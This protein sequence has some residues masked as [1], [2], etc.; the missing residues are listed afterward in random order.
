MVALPLAPVF[1]DVDT[2]EPPTEVPESTVSGEMTA[3][4]TPTNESVS[5]G[6]PPE[7]GT[8]TESSG[9]GGPEIPIPTEDI[10]TSDSESTTSLQ[11]VVENTDTTSGGQNENTSTSSQH[12][13]PSTVVNADTTSTSENV[14]TD[15]AP[16]HTLQES[17]T[18]AYT[19]PT[20]PLVNTVVNDEN[21]FSF[22][23]SECTT[24][25]DGTY[26]C[27]K[28]KE[29]PEVEHTDRVFSAVDADGDLE[30]FL[31]KDGEITQIT[32]N[33]LDDDA[34]YYDESSNSLTWHRLIDG[35]YQIMTYDIESRT[36]RQV[37]FDR[38]NNMQPSRFGDVIVWQGW[39]GND[40][41]VFMEKGNEQKMITDNTTHDI[42]PRINGTHII[43]QAYEN[44]TWV[45]KVYDIRTAQ[46]ETIHGNDGGSVENPR[47]VLV[48]DTKTETGDV[49]VR[50][51]DLDSGETVDL[52]ARP[53]PIPKEIP[54]PDQTGQDRALV[55]PSTQVVKEK[56]DVTPD[57]GNGN[58][59]EN[60]RDNG[61]TSESDI[62]LPPFISTGSSTAS[63][64]S[65][66]NSVY[67][68]S[69][70]IS[71][72]QSSDVVVPMFEKGEDT[73]VD[74]IPTIIVTPY[75]EPIDIDM[76]GTSEN[77]QI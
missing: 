8:H 60:E 74:T 54:N 18:T 20:K 51:Y 3:S 53:K 47:F 43:W 32:H 11:I 62:I 33:Q 64:T 59:P 19:E 55:S 45:M 40:W 39:V 1:A 46:I 65:I 70:K 71:S 73:A 37:T 41:E 12:E 16:Q 4:D 28:H 27:V 57:G 63:S 2:T 23:K 66:E 22:A 49:S 61:A 31:E 29:E 35:R 58:D 5:N 25:S 7:D 36:E 48:Y 15:T 30:I 24:M 76:Q 6:L 69:A 72:A 38:Y 44:D 42:S 52:G 50:G 75:V 77:P 56:K 67:D 68:S 26:Y 13:V 21:R 10:S 17:T 34:P 9:N 14:A